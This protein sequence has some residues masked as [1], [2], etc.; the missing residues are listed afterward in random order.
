MAWL[1]LS[2]AMLADA[3]DSGSAGTVLFGFGCAER[4]VSCGVA[5]ELV[6]VGEFAVIMVVSGRVGGE[7][8]VL[9]N[10]EVLLMLAGVSKVVWTMVGSILEAWRNRLVGWL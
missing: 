10:E 5:Q 9:G 2:I 4:M 8:F 7:L 6:V 1:E 3:A